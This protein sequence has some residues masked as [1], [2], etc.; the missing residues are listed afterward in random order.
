MKVAAKKAQLQHETVP[1]VL[2][3]GLFKENS[4][5]TFLLE[6]RL[7]ADLPGA[8]I[9]KNVQAH[10]GALAAAEAMLR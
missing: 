10:R 3:G 5:L 6:T 2:S 9:L 1:L 8:E 7:Q 4:V